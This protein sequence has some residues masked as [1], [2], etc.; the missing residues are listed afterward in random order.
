MTY[1]E[2]T[3]EIRL[4]DATSGRTVTVIFSEQL[5]KVSTVV[6]SEERYV[7]SRGEK[8][9][10]EE[11]VHCTLYRTGQI[12][13]SIKNHGCFRTNCQNGNNREEGGGRWGSN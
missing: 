13:T 8:F 7:S 1:T 3:K 11:G 12:V 9:L 6:E 4:G 2:G 10:W 5:D